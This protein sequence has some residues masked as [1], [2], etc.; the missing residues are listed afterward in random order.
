MQTL[1]EMPWKA[2]IPVKASAFLDLL[3]VKSVLEIIYEWA[4]YL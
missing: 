3:Q 1:Q 4:N 2:A